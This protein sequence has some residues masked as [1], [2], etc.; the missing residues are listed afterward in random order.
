MKKER[1]EN[2]EARKKSFQKPLGS[3]ARGRQIKSHGVKNIGGP[4]LGFQVHFD[5]GR[6]KKTLKNYSILFGKTAHFV[7]T[8]VAVSDGRDYAVMVLK[9]AHHKGQV[10]PQE[11]VAGDVF[12]HLAASLAHSQDEKNRW[13]RH[14]AGSYSINEIPSE[15]E[16]TGLKG[17]HEGKTVNLSEMYEE[18]VD[19]FPYADKLFVLYAAQ[20]A[21]RGRSDDYLRALKGNHPGFPQ[22][23]Y[24][25][26]WMGETLRQ[27]SQRTYNSTVRELA[28]IAEGAGRNVSRR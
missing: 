6:L 28:S 4:E 16:P 11:H 23:G 18:G 8:R 10:R 26:A 9:T 3:M 1:Y 21:R 14:I 7:T 20:G 24:L 19:E 15:R 17:T 27:L 12:D 22:V 25:D 2:Y 5:K 13:L